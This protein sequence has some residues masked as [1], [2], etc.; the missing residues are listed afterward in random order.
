MLANNN[1]IKKQ[2]KKQFQRKWGWKAEKEVWNNLTLEAWAIWS[3]YM[4]PTWVLRCGD[5]LW[6]HLRFMSERDVK[7]SW[8]LKI[9]WNVNENV[10][11][12]AMGKEGCTFYS[13]VTI[14]RSFEREVLKSVPLWQLEPDWGVA[15][16]H[17]ITLAAQSVYNQPQADWDIRHTHSYI[18]RITEK[19]LDQYNFFSLSIKGK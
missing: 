6:C 3:G 15:H 5:V 13:S 10:L 18:G 1:K 7:D 19:A 4:E 8:R 2:N 9:C 12:C 14:W 17:L 11:F 16:L